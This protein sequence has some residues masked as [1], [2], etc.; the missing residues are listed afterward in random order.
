M[1]PCGVIS[2]K[3]ARLTD[4]WGRSSSTE[5][6]RELGLEE[7]DEDELELDD[8]ELDEEE[9]EEE[10]EL[11]LD[12]PYTTHSRRLSKKKIKDKQQFQNDSKN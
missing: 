8:E 7:E 2:G 10:E 1:E 6:R 4:R 12:S 5:K 11:E 9:L 3:S